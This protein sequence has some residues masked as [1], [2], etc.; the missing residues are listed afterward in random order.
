MY[1][2]RYDTNLFKSVDGRQNWHILS[3]CIGS[4]NVWAQKG[5]EG[6]NYFHKSGGM[7]VK[8]VKR[9]VALCVN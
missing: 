1:L 2:R 5:V 8:G 3:V 6:G 7:G 9:E 4:V